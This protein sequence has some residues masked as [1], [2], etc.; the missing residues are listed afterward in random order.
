M[1]EQFQRQVDQLY[2][3][4]FVHVHVVLFKNFKV[5]SNFFKF[6]SIIA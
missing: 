2:P 5:K 1:A 3:K 6:L 4:L